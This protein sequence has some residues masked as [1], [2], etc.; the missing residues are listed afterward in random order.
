MTLESRPHFLPENPYE[1]HERNPDGAA[2]D[3]RTPSEILASLPDD[4]Q[5]KCW[6]EWRDGL[7]A[8]QVENLYR[9][10]MGELNSERARA[11]LLVNWVWHRQLF[12]ERHGQ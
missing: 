5:V 4:V 9:L 11:T 6:E 2:D 12:L 10:A 3:N 7:D 8:E 1:T